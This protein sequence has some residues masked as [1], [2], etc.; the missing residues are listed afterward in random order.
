MGAERVD[1]TADQNVVADPWR[2]AYLRFET[3]AQEIRKFAGRL[4]RAGQATWPRHAR[5]AELFCG[6]GNG[7]HAL[8]Q[9]GFTNLYGVDL[10]PALAS[11]YHGRGVIAVADCRAIPLASSSVD[12]A[13]V[14]GGLHHLP[15]IPDDL[16]RTMRE[17]HRI[18]AH[19]GRFL[20]VEPWR[21]PF[22]DAVHWLTRRR[23]ARRAWPK[24]DA[25]ATMIDH[26]RA[27]YEAWLAR[28]AVVLETL[29]RYFP[30][31][32]AHAARGKL[33]FTATRT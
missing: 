18:L 1:G 27:T 5:V 22:L 21:T 31:H 17:V 14:Q 25:L 33:V 16:D 24:L 20:A 8:A 30:D 15:V 29:S 23:A 10:S 19:G 9:L 2:D 28:P 26:E 4:D 13:V 12:V 7:L 32:T 6:R 11:L 3:P